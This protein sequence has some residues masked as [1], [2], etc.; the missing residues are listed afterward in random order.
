[1]KKN[2]KA[3]LMFKLDIEKAFDNVSWECLFNVMDKLGFSAKW[4]KWIKGDLCSP[5][6][7]ILVNG[8]AHGYIRASKGVCQGDPLSLAIFVLIMDILSFMIMKLRNVN[9]LFG[10]AM[11]EDMGVGEVT[12]L[13]FADDSLIFCD[14]D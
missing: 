4:H 11:N 14:A 6:I 1:M 5:M 13:L 2:R 3:R 10:F 7:S 12:H 9:G 8:E